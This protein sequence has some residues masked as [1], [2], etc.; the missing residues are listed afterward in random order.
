MKR[1][2][3]A[4]LL[5][6]PLAAQAPSDRGEEV[7]SFQ[8]QNGLR[9]LLLENHRHPLVRLQLRAAW[10]PSEARVKAPVPETK[11]KLPGPNAAGP[12]SLETLALRMLD[13]CAAGHRSRQAFNRALEER[14]LSLRLSGEPD[15]PVWDLSGGSPEAE[16]AF[17]LLADAV[18]R[19][20]PQGGDLDTIRLN[21]INDLHEQGSEE[22]ARTAFLRQLER[23]DL[24]LEPITEKNLGGIYLEDLQRY[25]A[26]SL[27]P[28]R[29]VL[30]ISGDLTLSQARQMV[31]L[32]FGAWA[33]GSGKPAVL[34]PPSAGRPLAL[35]AALVPADH[36]ET[37]LAL[38]FRPKDKRQRAAQELLSLWLPRCLG[39]DRCQIHP[40]AGGWRSLVLTAETPADSLK[41]ELSAFRQ[42]GLQA[43]DLEQSKALWIAT[44]R[45]MALHP[46]EQLSWAARGALL[47]PEPAELDI[48]TIDLAAVNETLRAWLDLDSARVLVFGGNQLRFPP[49]TAP[50]DPDSG[51][52]RPR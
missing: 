30:A 28:N 33:E 39:P 24:A 20:M 37:S 51:S 45:A 3:A 38:S 18:A 15:G 43:R 49:R 22:N 34:P 41:E 50:P 29:A 4:I 10:T 25:I 1:L 6:L 14:G 5:V 21:F 8:M 7:Q 32:N 36:L 52:G 40:G 16:F 12:M 47:G 44:R 11:S 48:Q 19:P 42:S 35:P 17:A 46:Q 9:V 2:M 13:Q 27:R 31:Q 23:P 26:A